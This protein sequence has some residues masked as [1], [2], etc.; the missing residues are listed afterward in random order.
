MTNA[1]T[2]GKYII[3]KDVQFSDYMKDEDGNIKLYNT[4]ERA[5]NVCG[6]YEFEDVLICKIEFNHIEPPDSIWETE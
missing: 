1:E 2:V 5:A 6:M 3:I 4:F